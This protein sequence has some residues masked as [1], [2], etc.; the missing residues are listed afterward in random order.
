MILRM[1]HTSQL[2][3]LL[4]GML[5]ACKPSGRSQCMAQSSKSL[6]LAEQ[7]SFVQGGYVHFGDKMCSAMFD[8]VD[9][10]AERIRLKAF[11]ARHCRFENG[12]DLQKVKVSLFL[13]AT[14]SRRAGYIKDIPAEESFA[15]RASLTMAEVAKINAPELSLLFADALR[16]PTH[17]DPWGG[18]VFSDTNESASGNDGAPNSSVICNNFSQIAPIVDPSD[19]LT[20]SCWSFLDLGT[21]DL[22]IKKSAMADKDFQLL[23]SALTQ[24][25]KALSNYLSKNTSLNA[26]YGAFRK[27]IDHVMS[28][29]RIQKAARL[30]YLLNTDLCKFQNTPQ[31]LCAQQKKLIEIMGQNFTHPTESGGDV[32]IFDAMAR[33][34]AEHS[35]EA[36]PAL[37]YAELLAGKRLTFATPPANFEQLDQLARSKAGEFTTLLKDKTSIA[38]VDLRKWVAEQSKG[39]PQDSVSPALIAASNFTVQSGGVKRELRFGLFNFSA[40]TSDPS[41][42]ALP[43]ESNSLEA[44]PVHGISRYGT[45]RMGAPRESQIVKFQ[46]TDS[47]SLLTLH[48]VIPLLVLNTVD[49]VPTSG[50]SAI[51]ALPSIEEEGDEPTVASASSGSKGSSGKGNVTTVDMDGSSASGPI[52]AACK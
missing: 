14:Q 34:F 45:L 12:I 23:T 33:N 47:G 20:E 4:C 38:I 41:K 32:S 18:A 15:S 42:I 21:F 46:P 17:Y 36:L 5:T 48:G 25:Q 35:S 3:A 52:V 11:S 30:A 8:V 6:P 26:A 1:R 28:L 29:L 22:S 7:T 44:F 27:E 31:A 10:T 51:L 43:V 2:L 19:R 13:D 50:G 24:K 37:S 16:I 39:T 9:V 49:D 40:V